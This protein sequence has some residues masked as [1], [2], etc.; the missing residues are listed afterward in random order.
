MINI[1]YIYIFTFEKG[2]FL[3]SNFV[4]H[5]KNDI[6]KGIFVNILLLKSNSITSVQFKNICI[7]S[8]DASF[9]F[10]L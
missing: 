5:V 8:S 7:K 2:L 1:Y 6:Y 9:K 3:I 10:L 4:K